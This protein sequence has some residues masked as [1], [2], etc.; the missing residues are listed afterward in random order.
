MGMSP[1]D[2]G[3]QCAARRPVSGARSG[4]AFLLCYLLDGHDG[5]HD[6]VTEGIEWTA[7]R[8]Q[9]CGGVHLDAVGDPS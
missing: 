7:T 8:M 2:T 4:I 5:P 1:S 3:I 9:A 6:D